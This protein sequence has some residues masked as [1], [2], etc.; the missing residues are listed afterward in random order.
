M[1]WLR[2]FLPKLPYFNR[3]ILTTNSG[4]VPSHGSAEVAIENTWPGVG[5]T[6]VAVTDLRPGGSAEFPDL[7]INDVRTVGVVSESG[8]VAAGTQLVIRE[9]RGT[10]IVVR[11]VT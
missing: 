3:L 8:Y 11:A 5:T 9:S 7:G 6:G 10:R 2:S 1:V 4:D